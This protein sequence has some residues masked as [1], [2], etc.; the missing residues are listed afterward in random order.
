MTPEN[1]ADRSI[2]MLH[3]T[4][5]ANMRQ[6]ALAF[7]Q[8]GILA[9][10]HTTIAWRPGSTLDR[11]L[12]DRLRSEL[13]RRSFPD[14][15]WE[16]VH[17]HPWHE[18]VRL[19]AVR[20]GWHNLIRHG[21]GQFNSDA[22]CAELDRTV[23]RILGCGPLPDAVYAVDNCALQTFREAKRRGVRRIYEMPIG[24]SRAWCALRDEEIA[25][26]PLWGQTISASADSEENL[27]SKD[28]EIALASV[29]MTPSS[30]VA[31]TLEASPARNVVVVPYGCP[32]LTP[33]AL[34]SADLRRKR[35]EGPLRVLYVG[36]MSQRKGISYLLQ[37]MERLGAS[38]ELTLV[39][40]LAHT[41]QQMAAELNRHR[42][43]A[44]MVHEQVLETMRNSDVLVLPTLF[45]G[46]ALVVLEALSQGLPVIT[47]LN[48]GTEDLVVDGV[49]GF[50]VPIRST[51]GIV[52]ALTRM[53]EDRE[54]VTAMSEAA[55]RAAAECTWGT[56][57]QRLLASIASSFAA[58]DTAANL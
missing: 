50:I 22:I 56:Y 36:S 8:A 31:R 39:G 44:T 5:N 11:L 30:F 15:P 34:E 27:A 37:A 28:E 2:L 25:L 35:G 9:G 51:A 12:P 55:F 40:R 53:I 7:N 43:T 49:T 19:I 54:L 29:V 46:R 41:N 26:E 3:M 33:S 18:L 24:H 57:R 38:A 42:W 1:L 45:E 52:A 13:A 20:M 47:T 48:S 6:A 17:S 10:L 4:G 23:A 32:S 14:L 21:T 58:D 16:L